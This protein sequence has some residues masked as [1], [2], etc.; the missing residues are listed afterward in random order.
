MVLT[1]TP[2]GWLVGS[3]S[4]GCLVSYPN[5]NYLT[6][7]KSLSLKSHNSEISS[8]VASDVFIWSLLDFN[9]ILNPEVVPLDWI[10]LYFW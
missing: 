7:F 5:L 6:S 3:L 9:H 10:S 4:V 1:Y 2:E 8:K